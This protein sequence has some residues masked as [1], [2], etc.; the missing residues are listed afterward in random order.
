MKKTLL[1]I[2]AVSL[3][4]FALSSC[5]AKGQQAKKAHCSSCEQH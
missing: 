1:A 2:L 3:T 4:A 5:A